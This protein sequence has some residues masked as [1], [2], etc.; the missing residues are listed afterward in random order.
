MVLFI[1]LYKLVLTFD[2]VDKILRS[3]HSNES[4]E[5]YFHLIMY[6]SQYFSIESCYLFVVLILFDLG[7]KRFSLFCSGNTL[8]KTF[9]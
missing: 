3:D 9:P 1:T 4:L 2:A 8:T 7:M 6:V 5:L